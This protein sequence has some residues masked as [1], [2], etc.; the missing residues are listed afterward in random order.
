MSIASSRMRV[1][2]KT[3]I[4]ARTISLSGALFGWR[5]LC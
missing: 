1:A 3:V 5:V 4:V 2:M